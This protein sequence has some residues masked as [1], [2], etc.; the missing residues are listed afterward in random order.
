M[1]KGSAILQTLFLSFVSLI[2]IVGFSSWAG[3]N[4]KISRDSLER[5]QALQIAEAGIDYYRWH[6]AHAQ[7]DY[8]DG[9]TST[10]PYIHDFFDKSGKKIGSF[11]LTITPPPLGSSLVVVQSKGQLDYSSTTRTIRGKFLIPS[12]AK[13]A[14]V[15]NDNIRFGEGTEVFGEIHSNGGIRFD[16]LAHNIISSAKYKY[17]DPDH[18]GAEEYGVHT[19]IYPTDPLPTSTLPTRTDIFE[20]G[21]KIETPRVDFAGLTTDLNAIKQKADA[22]KRYFSASGAMGYHAVLKTNDTFDL[23]KVTSVSNS[24]SK[25]CNNTLDQDG[26]GIW[27]IS[28][29][30]WI[31]NYSFPTSGV[32]FFEDNLWIDGQINTARLTIGVAKFYDSLPPLPSIIIN[33]NLKYTNYDGR[34]VIGLIAQNNI[35]IGWKSADIL[36]VDAALVAQNG[37]V[38]RYYYSPANFFFSKCEPYEKRKE[39]TL[40]GMIA[41]YQRYGFA[42]TDGTGYEQRNI[43]YDANLLYNPPPDFPLAGDKYDLVSWEEI[44]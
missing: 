19:H 44:E 22:D 17:D 14:V 8:Q 9:T 3:Y 27:S 21:R 7:K 4:I 1:K 23:Y 30:D 12:L 33:E 5:E 16:G 39:I 18:A 40:Y 28:K 31:N 38:G 10:G 35:N 20:I 24:P 29:E 32:M 34:D 42:Y 15:T 43:I 37:R 6:L 11:S 25:H 13:Y 26:W 2:I 36:R 41:T